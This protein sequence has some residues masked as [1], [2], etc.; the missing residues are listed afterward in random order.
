M[1]L[2]DFCSSMVVRHWDASAMDTM[3][4]A[5][6][7]HSRSNVHLLLFRLLEWL[8]THS[9]RIGITFSLLW[10]MDAFVW[11]RRKRL[12]ALENLDRQ[13]LAAA[14]CP[15]C[16]R[17]GGATKDVARSTT[18][19]SSD[20][21]NPVRFHQTWT[22]CQSVYIRTMALQVLLLPVGFVESVLY[23]LLQVVH[24][25]DGTNENPAPLF[26]AA[27]STK[28]IGFAL[29]EYLGTQTTRMLGER[30]EH[31]RLQ[32]IR[33]LI[34]LLLIYGVRH[35]FRFRRRL[36]RWLRA[37]RWVKHLVPIVGSINKLRGNCGDV[38]KRYRQFR[39]TR[40]AQ[41]LRVLRRQA[42]SEQ[43]LQ[44]YCAVLLQKMVRSYLVRRKLRVIRIIQAHEEVMAALR[45]QRQLRRWMQR[46]KARLRH[47]WQE[48]ERLHA[49]PRI[50]MNADERRRM[51]VLQT[52]LRDETE[53][54]LNKRLLLRPNT[55]FSVLWKL[56]F[57]FFAM[58][59]I[60]L[61]VTTPYAT[62]RIDP[63]T[64][65]SLSLEKYIV[66]NFIPQRLDTATAIC[67]LTTQ[68][69][70]S[71][72]WRIL[73]P[74]SSSEVPPA[75]LPWFCKPPYKQLQSN[76]VLVATFLVQN[77]VSIFWIVSFLDVF[78]VFF[79]GTYNRRTGEL[80]P[81][82]FIVRWIVPGLCFQ[83][84]VNDKVE[85]AYSIVRKIVEGLLHH[86]PNRVLRWTIAIFFPLG[87]RMRD[88]VRRVLYRYITEQNRQ[89]LLT[90][91]R[92]VQQQ[93]GRKLHAG[94][95]AVTAKMLGLD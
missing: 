75:P 95:G 63:A 43:E 88:M 29:L 93:Q 59:E 22:K 4:V 60:I 6:G 28:S 94:R 31:F 55:P 34:R 14:S 10:F 86:G 5:P 25:E 16:K 76:G 24:L 50:T 39:N 47:D 82:P 79:T 20:I 1:A 51:Y 91:K 44:H 83:L 18:C 7:E 23:V 48:L 38:L 12:Q 80:E 66:A 30:I 49:M 74:S 57:V 26:A 15:C 27:N 11:A 56:M 61:L 17:N 35:P 64:G 33:R 85:K 71:R 89:V 37:F 62:Q 81:A 77:L 13:A 9:N 2:L 65:K 53:Y 41:N 40:R 52:T 72:L 70:R 73:K 90:N 54:L 21:Q 36:R 32:R 58:V 68:P 69:K 19:I 78:V 3:V 8:R 87:L 92:D 67:Q 84:L 42:L 45:L 46:S